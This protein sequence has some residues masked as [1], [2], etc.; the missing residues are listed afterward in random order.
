MEKCDILDCDFNKALDI[1]KSRFVLAIVVSLSEKKSSFSEI[2]K[3]FSYLTNA[4]LSRTLKKLCDDNLIVKDE[5]YYS[6][7]P[8]G[9][10]LT[11]IAIML[12]KWY[13]K[14]Y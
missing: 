4:T 7:T 1:I 14:H 2:S 5:R 13:E 10:E 3:E 9:T 8:A 6:L 12:E 11:E